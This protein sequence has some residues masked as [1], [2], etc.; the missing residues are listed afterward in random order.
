MNNSNSG[1]KILLSKEI[2]SDTDFLN[3]LS[4][5]NYFRGLVKIFDQ[6]NYQ[7]FVEKAYR[8]DNNLEIVMSQIEIIRLRKGIFTRI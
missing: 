7:K 1:L 2:D 5:C 3:I 6:N 4:D 8:V